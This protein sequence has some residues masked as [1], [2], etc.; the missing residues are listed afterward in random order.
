MKKIKITLTE[1]DD[2]KTFSLNQLKDWFPSGKFDRR[3]PWDCVKKWISTNRKYLDFLGILY[4]WGNDKGLILEASNKIGLAPIKNPYGGKVYGSITVKPRIGWI[5]IS[6]ILDSIEWRLKPDFLETEEPIMSEGVLPRWLKA[7]DTLKAIERA[8]QCCLRGIKAIHEVKDNPVG[9]VNWNNYSTRNVP[10]GKWNRFSCTIA[11]YSLDIDIH[12]QFKGIVEQIE[13]DLSG[14]YVPIN[15]KRKA[16][17]TLQRIKKILEKVNLELPDVDKLKNSNIPPFYRSVYEDAKTRAVEYV[18][19]S[20]FSIYS[21]EFFGL[22]WAIEMDRL[23]ESWVEFW[24]Y[25]FSR[26]MGANFYSDIRGNSKIRFLSLGRWGGL[27]DLKPD[28]IIDKGEHTMVIDVKYKKHLL[29]LKLGNFT[30]DILEEHR[31]DIHQI[32]AYAGS[33]SNTD[34]KAVLVYP[35]LLKESIVEKAEVINYKNSNINLT[36]LKIDTSFDSSEFL[37]KLRSTWKNDVAKPII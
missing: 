6:E 20:R 31:K 25:K 2:P 4:S 22:P 18:S 5:K 19:Q 12:R 35:K 21:A 34:K 11:D 36:L 30:R 37:E 9:R 14:H 23:F 10:Y 32:L 29:Y 16:L 1:F 27:K 26:Q 33:S 15:V 8:L 13:K 7:I 3:M 28:I 17:P 24:S